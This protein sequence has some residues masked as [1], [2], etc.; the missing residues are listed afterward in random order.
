[1][2]GKPF[3][4]SAAAAPEAKTANE[5]QGHHDEPVGDLTFP[6]TA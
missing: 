2:V 6:I 4:D 1:M 5:C 3:H